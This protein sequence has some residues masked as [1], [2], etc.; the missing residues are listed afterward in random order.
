M[1]DAEEPL[2]TK[3]DRFLLTYRATPTELGKSPSELL[4]NRQ[5]QIRL[6]ALRAKKS[7]NEVKIFQ[8]NPDNKPKYSLSQA[9][10]ARNFGKGPRWIPGVVIRIISPRNY[11]VQVS[12]VVWKRHEE[13]LR[14]RQI[15]S[16]E[17]AEQAKYER[18]EQN[19]L[20][21]EN[22]GTNERG[23]ILAPEE[24]SVPASPTTVPKEFDIS[25]QSTTKRED[26]D[27]KEL[28]SKADTPI[29][30]TPSESARR[31]PLRERKPPKR[32]TE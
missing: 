22:T 12:D 3:L 2:Q 20:P 32:F 11:D 10:F 26:V 24:D 27:T 7:G 28:C 5:P 29:M 8:D 13:Q 1:G 6:S 9:V 25:T 17:N 19:R 14:P 4:M 18:D 30:V 23:T 16:F 21:G 15:P 31:Y